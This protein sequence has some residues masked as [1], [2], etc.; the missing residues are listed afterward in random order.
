MVKSGR[1]QNLGGVTYK[2]VDERGRLYIT[3]LMKGGGGGERESL[4]LEVDNIVV[5]AG[6][7][8]NNNL[9]ITVRG[10]NGSLAVGEGE[11]GS[12][13]VQ[14]DH[15]PLVERFFTVGGAYEALDI[16][17]KRVI[18]MKNSLVLKI[19]ERGEG[20]VKTGRHVL[21]P[22]VG[23]EE[24]IMDFLKRYTGGKNC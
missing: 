5:C 18:D 2:K 16:D 7:D 8:Y 12:G 11:E 14:D 15:N 10:G 1:L 9:E 24:H 17:A 23:T 21:V 22:K 20:A 13:V 3:V 19:H 6:H 4:I